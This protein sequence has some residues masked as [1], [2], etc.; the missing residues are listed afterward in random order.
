MNTFYGLC[1]DD[2]KEYNLVTIYALLAKTNNYKKCD[3]DC[4]HEVNYQKVMDWIE[5]NL[6]SE[7]YN[8]IGTLIYKGLKTECD[9]L[10]IRS[11]RDKTY[12]GFPVTA[13]NFTDAELISCKFIKETFKQLTNENITVTVWNLTDSIRDQED[14]LIRAVRNDDVEGVEAFLGYEISDVVLE[15]LDSRLREVMDQMPDEEY[16]L[17][18]ENT[19]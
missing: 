2:I 14:D 18:L 3:L 7:E 1:V 19:I 11:Y 10:T 8:G 16:S 6:K 9:I 13:A 15:E 17:F 4:N 5:S 12:L